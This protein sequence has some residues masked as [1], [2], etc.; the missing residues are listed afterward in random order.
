MYGASSES[1]SGLLYCG[2]A[3]NFEPHTRIPK[4]MLLTDRL[5]STAPLSPLSAS[6]AVTVTTTVWDPASSETEPL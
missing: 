4:G 1:Q 5:Y 6:V 3:G 2:I